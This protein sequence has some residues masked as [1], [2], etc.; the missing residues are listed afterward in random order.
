MPTATLPKTLSFESGV[1]LLSTPINL[2][3]TT[4]YILVDR[5]HPLRHLVVRL[6]A[7]RSRLIVG[8]SASPKCLSTRFLRAS[9][10]LRSSLASWEWTSFLKTERECEERCEMAWALAPGCERSVSVDSINSWMMLDV[11]VEDAE[12][13][14]PEACP[15]VSG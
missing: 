9:M 4:I 11:R 10:P 14:L 5:R 8:S 3:L 15:V 12:V 6:L 1:D 13:Y 2:H 7:F